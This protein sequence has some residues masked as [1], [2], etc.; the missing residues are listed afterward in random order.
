MKYSLHIVPSAERQF[1][2]LQT[3]FQNR[4][5]N[6][7]FLLESDPRP[8]GSQ[9]LHGTDF[10]RIRVGD[11]RVIYSI[12]DPHKTIKILDIGHRREVYRGW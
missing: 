12:N 4:I 5:K 6:K 11:Y 7:I 8:Y 1:L 10:F 3:V 9:K 2:K